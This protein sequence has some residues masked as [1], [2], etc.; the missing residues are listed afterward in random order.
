MRFQN[1]ALSLG[2]VLILAACGDNDKLAPDAARV[3]SAVP[4]AAPEP[5]VARG[6]YLVNHVAA[7]GDCHTPR[8]MNGMPDTTKFLSGVEC[9]IDANGGGANTGCL[10]SRNLTNHA[11]G[12]MNRS[13]AEIKTM[14]QKGTRPNGQHLIPVMPYWVFNN[15]T[16]A[17]A[18][19]I[20]LYLR[21]V[22]G[23]DHT[24]PANDA[25]FFPPPAA[26]APALSKSKIPTP[27][28]AN[29]STSNGRY[30][31]SIACVECHT[32]LTNPMDFRSIDETKVLAGNRDFPRDL[33]GL[34]PQFPANI[35]TANLTPHATG[36]A[37]WTAA[38]I[39]AVLKQG[40]DQNGA[41][42]CP[43]MPGGSMAPFGGLTDQDAADIA[44]YIQ[45]IPAVDNA[46]TGTCVAP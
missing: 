46:I 13:D 7:C 24:V 19:S 4:D 3:D 11:T 34:P 8:L 28:T 33:L 42:V 18:Q 5:S 45:A 22:T 12:L 17:D 9:F 14:F 39:I 21:T 29:A 36:L 26:A 37:G 16:D 41:G 43:P 10:H 35:Y 23:V 38:Q 31:A 30:L 6:D 2:A 20:V 25:T 27:S 44:A 32:A 40:V 15:L 1:L